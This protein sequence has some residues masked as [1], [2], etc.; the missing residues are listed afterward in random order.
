M[1]QPCALMER[2]SDSPR[3]ARASLPSCHGED[4]PTP[5]PQSPDEAGTR[6][7]VPSP[8]HVVP[9]LQAAPST[10]GPR[11]C[12]SSCFPSEKYCPGVPGSSHSDSPEPGPRSGSITSSE[13]VDTFLSLPSAWGLSQLPRAR[14][15]CH[16]ILQNKTDQGTRGRVAH[17]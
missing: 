8:G 11:S 5:D 16:H 14:G 1:H 15:D 3:L 10:L 9:H 13:G 17:T 6:P 7:E 4:S 12:P 2:A